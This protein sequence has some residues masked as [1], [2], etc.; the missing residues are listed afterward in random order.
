MPGIVFFSSTYFLQHRIRDTIHSNLPRFESQLAASKSVRERLQT[1][2][3][4]VDVLHET[5]SH[6]EVRSQS[7]PYTIHNSFTLEKTGLVS[8]VT[9]RF[10]RH[11]AL[12]QE[13]T[14]TSIYYKA[15]LHLSQCRRQYADLESLGQA[16]RLPEAILASRELDNL[17]GSAPTAL[18]RSK[19][20]TDFK[21][22]FSS[23][24]KDLIPTYFLAQSAC[25]ESFGGRTVER[26]VF[27]ECD[28]FTSR[29]R[30]MSLR[31]R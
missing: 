25:S 4:D 13:A 22:R 14:N 12:V 15:L 9:R 5:V 28:P 7:H 2:E 8:T 24:F 10:A 17:L 30:Y 23:F 16:G 6:P 18:E 11:G 21:V 26:R 19:I 31:S 1:L 3:S 27:K 20:L 29:T